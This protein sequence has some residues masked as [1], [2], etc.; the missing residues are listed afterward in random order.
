[1][2]RKS[3]IF[4]SCSPEIFVSAS[5]FLAKRSSYHAAISCAVFTFSGI[6][7]GFV[8]NTPLITVS[9]NRFSAAAICL[10]SSFALL[11]F[12]SGLYSP[13]FGG[14]ASRTFLVI[15]LSFFNVPRYTSCSKYT[16]CSAVISCSSSE[17]CWHSVIRFSAP[18]T[19]LSRWMQKSIQSFDQHLG[20]QT[21]CPATTSPI[22]DGGAFAF[23]T[24]YHLLR[25]LR[26]HSHF[27][28]CCAKVLEEGIKM[29]IVQSLLPRLR[30]SGSDLLA[31]IYDS[32]AQKHG[33]EHTLPGVQVLHVGCFEKVTQ[34]LIRFDSS[35]EGFRGRPNRESSTDQF[36]EVVDHGAL[37]NKKMTHSVPCYRRGIGSRGNPPATQSASPAGLNFEGSMREHLTRR[38]ILR[39]VVV[40]FNGGSPET[41]T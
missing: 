32:S 40:Y 5:K 24:F 10:T 8:S 12:G 34:S 9:R 22:Q 14:T 15:R 33:N 21:R 16:A 2:P 35:V 7:D 1:M 30:M 27:I 23:Q 39:L 38:P 26:F 19:S 17:V 41:P 11:E 28:E 36:I 6:S 37:L 4:V 29:R 18:R 25:A 13:L 20:P 31:G 3:T